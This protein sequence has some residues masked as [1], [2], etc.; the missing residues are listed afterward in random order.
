MV[1]GL[2]SRK[3]LRD[4]K[5]TE[6]RLTVLSDQDVVLDALRPLAY[7]FVQSVILPTGLMLPC[8]IPNP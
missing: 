2:V 3:R 4:R 1:D 6:M 5:V 7:G 8:K